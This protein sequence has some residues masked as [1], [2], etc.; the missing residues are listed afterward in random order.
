MPT[1]R[2]GV[3]TRLLASLAFGTVLNPLNSSMIAVALVPLQHEFGVG[4]ATSS[5]LVSGF[6][7]AAAVGQ[8]LMGRMVDLLGARRLFVGGLA[9]MCAVCAAAPFA[10]GF[11]W[12]VGIR[13][14]MAV[15]T[16]TAF[17]AALV[18]IRAAV[19]SEQP[20][21]QNS[22]GD[23]D[24]SG[25]S[26]NSGNGSRPP[27][28]ALAA[29]TV[30]ASTSA[31]L[32]PVLGGF[33]VAFAGWQAVFLVNVPFTAA[34]IML[35]VR[36]LP[37][38]PARTAG[39]EPFLRTVDLPGLLLFS[40]TLTGLLVFL[41]SLADRPQWWLVPLVVV[42]A[43]ALVRRELAAPAPFL[44]V[45]GLVANRALSSVLG[46]QGGVN[47]VFYC[48]F[49]GLPL[50]LGSVRGFGSD[51]V[52]LLILPLALMGVLMTPVAARVVSL[53]GSRATL[54]FGSAVLLAGT[55]VV[56]LLHESSPVIVIVVA[57]LLFGIPGGFNNLGLQT[58]LY[59]ASPPERM[60]S[61]GGLFQTFRYLGAILSTSVLGIVFERDL[62]TRGLHHVG[63]LMTAVAAVLLLLALARH[64]GRRRHVGSGNTMSIADGEA[65]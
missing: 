56:Q 16:S 3:P 37:K 57:A 26:G 23:S 49:F 42:L 11:W 13:V 18:L 52:G 24:D 17:P 38:P 40:A 21:G 39:A 41:L 48:V 58:A 31:A 62:S 46:Q 50:W 32:G 43:A 44:D 27:S 8:P 61:S 51:T 15:G 60:G 14:L 34:G 29:L 2:F 35:A 53:R 36:L 1:P 10:P 4:V 5:W 45:R 65:T 6:Y 22:A 19:E 47:L 55:L 9:L 12:L 25:N 28:A 7:L 33:L 63:W 20:A 64:G 54:V 59:E 30:A